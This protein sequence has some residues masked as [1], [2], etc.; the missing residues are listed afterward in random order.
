MTMEDMLLDDDFVSDRLDRTLSALAVDD[1]DSFVYNG[2]AVNVGT[3]QDFGNKAT[4]SSRIPTAIPA[5]SYEW[6]V[7]IGA[8]VVFGALLNHAGQR[9][10]S[11]KSKQ[12]V[13]KPKSAAAPSKSVAPSVPQPPVVSTLAR[14][15]SN[16]TAQSAPLPTNETTHNAHDDEPDLVSEDYPGIVTRSDRPPPFAARDKSTTTSQLD[17][18]LT[19]PVVLHTT[20]M[21]TA[22]ET[23]GLMSIVKEV[24]SDQGIDLGDNTSMMW[25]M[26]LQ[27][28][29]LALNAQEHNEVR[30]LTYDSAQRAIDRQLSSQQH[31]EIMEVQKSE[32]DWLTKLKQAYERCASWWV[33]SLVLS[34]GVVAL[35]DL[36][37]FWHDMS[38]L[39][40]TE[41]M[42]YGTDTV[43]DGQRRRAPV[44]SWSSPTSNYWYG[45]NWYPSY[46]TFGLDD[47]NLG[48]MATCSCYAVGRLSFVAL[49]MAPLWF[50]RSAL[51]RLCLPEHVLSGL[52]TA[53]LVFLLCWS[54]CIPLDY[55]WQVAT[56]LV[57]AS[58]S[59]HVVLR[60]MYE[61]MRQEFQSLGTTPSI[62]SVN[63]K[64]AWFDDTAHRILLLPVL[65]GVGYYLFRGLCK[66]TFLMA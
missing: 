5:D 41:L 36:A 23:I 2:Q 9:W 66:E 32:P 11:T 7:W 38:S 51:S 4:V 61:T 58:V 10:M 22:R 50:A 19:I 49:A 1:E 28:Q 21:D 64:L 31:E 52:C 16:E 40:W 25:A 45:M 20:T 56:L 12:A 54:E 24:A 62:A 30:R 6:Y 34:A 37:E 46:F 3:L 27:S 65:V 47:L 8:S 43:F 57:V 13:A 29:A 35:V 48:D 42:C 60:I 17:G 44:P 59:V 18:T 26:T 33:P 63:E 55:I 39:S 14:Q 15:V 53:Y